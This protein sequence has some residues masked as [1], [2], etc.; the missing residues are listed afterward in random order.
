MESSNKYQNGKIYKIWSLETDEI[1]VGSTCCPLHKRMYNHR[2][3]AK[4]KAPY[5]LHQEMARLGE[6][7]FKIEL[8]EDYPC[9]SIN[10][11][12]KREG[13]WIRELKATLNMR[14]AGRTKEEYYLDHIDETKEYKKKW[15]HENKDKLRDKLKNYYQEHKADILARVKAYTEEHVEDRKKYMQQYRKENKEKINAHKSETHICNVCGSVYTS[16]HKTR[17]ERTKKHLQA[18]EQQ[19]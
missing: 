14:I 12:N 15:Q 17:H 11:L 7:A 6:S 8:I 16:S 13:Y 4:K 2:C 10:D 19:N 3:D 18:L 1:Y 5:K 9:N